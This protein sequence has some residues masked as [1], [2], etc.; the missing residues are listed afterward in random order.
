MFLK[1]IVQFSV[2]IP[3]MQ[4]KKIEKVVSVEHINNA[5]IRNVQTIMLEKTSELKLFPEIYKQL[6]SKIST[7]IVQCDQK[8]PSMIFKGIQHLKNDKT[9]AF[10]LKLR[11]K[12]RKMSTSCSLKNLINGLQNK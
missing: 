6:F 11:K 12:F 2:D 3:S 9:E 7:K 5:T 8:R 10:R 1:I 4:F